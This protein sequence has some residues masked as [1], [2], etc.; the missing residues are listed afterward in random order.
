[1]ISAGWNC[2]GPAPSQRRAPLTFTP[3]P[4]TQHEHEQHERASSSS[5]V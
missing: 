5:G 2:S 3:K 4:G 1:M